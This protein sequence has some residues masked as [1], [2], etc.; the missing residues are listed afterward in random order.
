MSTILLLPF[1]IQFTIF[2]SGSTKSL[3]S[4]VDLFFKYI[5]ISELS[6]INI[7]FLNFNH[8]IPLRI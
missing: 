7:K 3:F 6:S 2:L 4:K 8:S 1:L 5:L